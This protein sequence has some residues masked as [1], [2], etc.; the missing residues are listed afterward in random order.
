MII[1][2]VNFKEDPTPIMTD[3]QHFL[4]IKPIDYTEKLR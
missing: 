2:G 1:N 3:V 4:E